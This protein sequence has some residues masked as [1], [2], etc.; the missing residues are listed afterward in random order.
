MMSDLW[1]SGNPQEFLGDDAGDTAYDDHRYLKFDDSVPVSQEGY[2]SE[3]CNNDRVA[4]DTLVIGEWS[5]SVND[6]VEGDDDWSPDSQKDFY[7]KWFAAQIQSYERSALGWVFWSWKAALN[8][9]RWS[10][11]GTYPAVCPKSAV[12]VCAN[13]ARRPRRGHH[14]QGPRRRHQLG[15]LLGVTWLSSILRIYSH[16]FYLHLFD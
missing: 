2:L 4:E 6:D 1:G 14:F 5:L 7:A 13:C 10:Y 16:N 11:K 8:D 3:S 12:C 15:C 9:P